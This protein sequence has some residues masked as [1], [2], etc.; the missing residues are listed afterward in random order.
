VSGVAAERGLGALVCGQKGGN[1]FAGFARS[2][3]YATAWLVALCGLGLL[4]QRWHAG[5]LQ[6]LALPFLLG[7]VVAVV[8]AVRRLFAGFTATY[9]YANGLV[10]LKNGRVQVVTWPE[11]DKLVLW[12]IGGR[13]ERYHLVTHDGRKVPVEL[14]SAQG[15]QTLGTMLQEIVQNL[16]RPIEAGGPSAGRSR[17]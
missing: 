6:L 3:A 10:H 4:F 17:R 14:A 9:L 2:M 1:P 7:A 16:G 12:E 13:L 11:L 5:P 8:T 15:D